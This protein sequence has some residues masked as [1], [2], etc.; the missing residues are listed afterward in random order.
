[1]NLGKWV[2]PFL[3]F[4]VALFVG[5]FIFDLIKTHL[6]EAASGVWGFIVSAVVL[7]IVYVG[8][9]KYVKQG[10]PPV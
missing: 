6:G 7:F 10:Q 4:L 5:G 1:M 2:A 3:V 9:I 8:L